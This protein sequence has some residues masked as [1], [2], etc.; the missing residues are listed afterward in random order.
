MGQKTCRNYSC[1]VAY[2]RADHEKK[3]KLEQ[4]KAEKAKRQE[5]RE[6]KE[7]LK[8]RSEW[9]QEAEKAVRD[10]RRVFELNAGSGCISCGRTQEEV[11]GTDAWK[12]GGAWDG[13]HFI[14]KGARANLRLEPTNIWL[15]CKSCNGGSSKYARKSATVS[16]GYRIGLIARI[17]IEAVEALESDHEP[18]KWTIDDLKQI[19]DEYR[20]KLKE[21]KENSC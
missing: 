11:Q 20:Q 2:G 5:L 15:Q 1:A 12:P 4:A 16:Q 17:G 18:R 6:R 13:G 9:V 19:R 7:K 14:G 21:L 3:A 10:Y 8:S